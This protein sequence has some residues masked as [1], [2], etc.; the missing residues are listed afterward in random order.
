M[1][2]DSSTH[3]LAFLQTQAVFAQVPTPQ[4]QWLIDNAQYRTLHA[5]E[6]LF[7]KDQAADFMNILLSGKINIFIFQNQTQKLLNVIKAGDIT[8]LLPYSRLKVS[9]ATGQAVEDTEVLAFHREKMPDLIQKNPELTQN[10]IHLMMDRSRDYNQQLILNDKMIALGKLS[11][12]LAHELNNPVSAIVRSADLLKKHLQLLPEG[13]KNVIKIRLPDDVVDEINGIMFERLANRPTLTLSAL[14]RSD[15]E[16]EFVNLLEDNGLGYEPE[17]A[18]NLVEYG[19]SQA[20]VEKIIALSTPQFVAP[21]LRWI[22]NNLIT[23]NMVDEI[24]QASQ[25]IDG[26]IKSI[27]SYSYMD[28]SLDLQAVDVH[29]GLRNTLQI[30]QHK[31]KKN[32]IKIIK[33][34]DENVHTIMGLPGELNQLWTNIIDNALDAMEGQESGTLT[35]RTQQYGE[36]VKIYV[37]DTGKGIPE[38][39]KN[40]IFD[41]FFTTKPIGKGTGLG[42]DIVQKIVNQHNGS[43]KVHSE[44]GNTEFMVCVPRG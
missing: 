18:Q 7:Q 5:G 26:L 10:L 24:R 14:D 27:K 6:Y 36:F 42:L 15:L 8:G 35:I 13:F 31:I 22:N 33:Q 21:I 28:Q 43:L 30:L 12:G 23:E 38:E 41:P 39:I 17:V 34:F 32:H 1:Q 40:K 29:E 9:V 16:D 4:L 2:V 37:Q 20:E 3:I 25:R 19:F 11:A 44:A